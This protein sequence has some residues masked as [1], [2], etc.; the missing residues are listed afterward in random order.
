M[1]CADVWHDETGSCA[2]AL[3]HVL[4]PLRYGM[5]TATTNVAHRELSGALQ[6]IQQPGRRW[7]RKAEPLSGG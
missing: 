6:V 7:M 1:I 2:G 3:V 4:N 5:T